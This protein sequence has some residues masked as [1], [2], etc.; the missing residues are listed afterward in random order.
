MHLEKILWPEKEVKQAFA[1]SRLTQTHF[2]WKVAEHF[3]LAVDYKVIVCGRLLFSNLLFS[4]GYFKA[5]SCQNISL[6]S[7]IYT[8]PPVNLLVRWQSSWEDGTELKQTEYVSDSFA[9]QHW[10]WFVCLGHSRILRKLRKPIM[11]KTI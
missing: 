4:Q 6:T 2:K 10:P 7:T 11:L 3:L 5:T 1:C 8:E 9:L